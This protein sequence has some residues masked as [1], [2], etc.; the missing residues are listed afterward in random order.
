MRCGK[1][2][3]VGPRICVAGKAR[4]PL[5]TEVASEIRTAALSGVS[6][7]VAIPSEIPDNIRALTSLFVRSD[8]GDALVSLAPQMFTAARAAQKMMTGGNSAKM[9]FAASQ[10]VQKYAS[11]LLTQGPSGARSTLHCS[12]CERSIGPVAP[13]VATGP[14][15]TRRVVPRRWFPVPCQKPSRPAPCLECRMHAFERS[16]ADPG[17]TGRSCRA[18]RG[19][20][21]H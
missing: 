20:G 13:R 1:S 10:A 12:G 7:H 5:T 19:S 3:R 4:A 2:P 17:C 14:Q 15:F 8:L 16:S 18:L 11:D 6:K 9:T 21:T